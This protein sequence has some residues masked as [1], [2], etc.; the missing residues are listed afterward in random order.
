MAEALIPAN[1]LGRQPSDLNTVTTARQPQVKSTVLFENK[2]GMTVA[3]P[4]LQQQLTALCKGI[5]LN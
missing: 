5:A 4:G 3:L 2:G 1:S